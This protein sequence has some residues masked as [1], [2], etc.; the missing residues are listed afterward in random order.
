[1][2]SF[3]SGSWTIFQTP[4]TGKFQFEALFATT[5]DSSM[6][7]LLFAVKVHM[8]RW[9][10]TVRVL[11]CE[12]K[13]LPRPYRETL[14]TSKHPLV[15]KVQTYKMAHVL[16]QYYA[17][18]LERCCLLVINTGWGNERIVGI[19]VKGLIMNYCKASFVKVHVH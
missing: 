9:H 10:E 15:K 3:A 19:L 4:G 8:L 11:E 7:G 12:L 5:R 17:V 13:A 1:M 16:L 18:L 2:S 6:R 14:Q